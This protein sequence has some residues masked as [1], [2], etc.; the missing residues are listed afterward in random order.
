MKTTK[1]INYLNEK[2]SP[3]LAADWDASGFQI[4]ETFNNPENEE[5]EKLMIC[6]DVT[7]EA[8]KFAIHEGIKFI[9]SRHPFIF[10]SIE[11]ELQNPAKSEMIKEIIE[12]NIQIFTIHTN[13][14]ASENQ[15]LTKLIKNEFDIL[16]IKRV[17]ESSEGFEFI[18]KK[19]LA[20]KN[21]LEKLKI[22]F[23]V[24]DLRITRDTDIDRKISNF[25]IC[26][27]AGSQTMFFEKMQNQV[28]VTGEGKWNEVIFAQDNSNDLILLGHYMENYFVKDIADKLNKEFNKSFKIVEFDVKNGWKKF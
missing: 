5:I 25:F 6:L 28:F 7:N 12:N 22:I 3:D 27:G 20:I 21:L 10:N 16:E 15:S 4:Q 1:I 23:N 8:L 24:E 17:G 14:D 9:I 18:F 19:E 11:Q 13:Y 26:T 2:F